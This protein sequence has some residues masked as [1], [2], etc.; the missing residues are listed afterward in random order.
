M[1]GKLAV[2]I[3]TKNEDLHIARC[4]DSLSSL[5]ADVF[6]VDSGSNDTTA[7]IANSYSAT[8]LYHKFVCQSQQINWAISNLLISYEW[9]IRLDADEYLTVDLA[10]LISAQLPLI[11]RH[12]NGIQVHR[13]LFFM[14]HDIRYGGINPTPC[15][16]IFRPRYATCERRLMDEHIV[17]SGLIHTFNAELIDNNLRPL[18]YW[19]SKH[20]EYSSREA[21]QS[22]FPVSSYFGPMVNSMCSLHGLP[23]V[24][25]FI[26]DNIYLRLPCSIRAFS[27][28]LIRYFLFFGFLDGF[29]GFC[30]HFLHAFVYRLVVDL[31]IIEIRRFLASRRPDI[32]SASEVSVA[33]YGR[34][35]F[36]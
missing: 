25:R 10:A 31:K 22:V 35:F 32:P 21:L 18:S 7:K 34:D 12:V 3:L 11:P 13:R 27:Y 33:L 23:A 5:S 6:I 1:T 20:N 30:F 19:L 9:V 28:F 15:L 24:K 17:V 16:R 14:Q 2:L 4:L 26:K 29:R 36:N 8:F